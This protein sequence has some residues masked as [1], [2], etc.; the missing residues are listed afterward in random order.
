MKPII[1]PLFLARPPVVEDVA[2]AESVGQ[3]TD[4]RATPADGRVAAAPTRSR[5]DGP[6]TQ[7]EEPHA[8]V[9]AHARLPAADAPQRHEPHSEHDMVSPSL[10][11]RARSMSDG[12]PDVIPQRPLTERHLHG[13]ADPVEIAFPAA[14]RRGASVLSPQRDDASQRM[15]AP[16]IAHRRQAPLVPREAK[17]S[18]IVAALERLRGLRETGSAPRTRRDP[19]VRV[20]IGRIEVRSTP[21]GVSEPVAPQ[22]PM[23]APARAVSPRLTLAEYLARRPGAR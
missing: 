5:F 19:V 10:V 15:T 20:S 21:A 2:A 9:N 23:P 17:A 8:G 12:M 11:D 13:P 22:P 6:D 16:A 7:A 18:D 14:Q 4:E 1:T 3:P